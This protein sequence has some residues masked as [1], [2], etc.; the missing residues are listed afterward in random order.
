SPNLFP[1][2][3][4]PSLLL[5]LAVP[6]VAEKI[7]PRNTNRDEFSR[8]ASFL[9]ARQTLVS[10]STGTGNGRLQPGSR[11]PDH[12]SF[13]RQRPDLGHWRGHPAARIIT[14]DFREHGRR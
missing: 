2:I 5:I 9:R 7:R 10:R 11:L 8:T 3:D 13:E 14:H 12:R 1:V 4:I 6:Q